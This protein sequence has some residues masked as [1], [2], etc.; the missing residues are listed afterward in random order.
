M[1]TAKMKQ[2]IISRKRIENLGEYEDLKIATDIYMNLIIKNAEKFDK[3]LPMKY[4]YATYDNGDNISSFHRRLYHG[5]TLSGKNI[6]NPF[7][8]KEGTFL[9]Y[10]KEI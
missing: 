3:F 1:I 5:L 2:G 9:Q 10:D 7:S 8:S 4:T 6:T